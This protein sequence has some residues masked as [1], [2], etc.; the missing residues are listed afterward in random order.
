MSQ[1]FMHLAEV[2]FGVVMSVLG[3]MAMV[4]F[5]RMAEDIKNLTIYVER[6]QTSANDL[7]V[8]IA[9]VIS[10]VESHGKR[11]E[12]LEENQRGNV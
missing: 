5:K 3:T 10:Q 9:V 7:N 1:E 4:I 6:L 2:G 11:I 12:D 8:R